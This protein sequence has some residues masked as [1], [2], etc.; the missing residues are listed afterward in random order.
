MLG[1]EQL[2]RRTVLRGLG[3]AAMVAPFGLTACSNGPASEPGTLLR[4]AQKKD[5]STLDPQ[6]QGGLESMNVLI[7]LFDTLTMRDVDNVLQPRLALS[8]SAVDE[9]TWRFVLRPG[10]KFHNGED[11][12]AEVVKFSI[13]RLIDPATKSTIVELRYVTSVNII[14][15]HTV[16]IISSTPDP[17]LPEKVSLFGGVMVPP[18]YITEVGSEGFAAKPIGTGPYTFVSWRKDYRIE[19]LANP[20][21]WN[22][23]PA[24]EALHFTPMPNAASALASLQSN[25]VDIVSGL[26]PEA[27][28]QLKG[29]AGVE[30]QSH[31]GIRMHFVVLNTLDPILGDVRVRRALNHAV[32]IPLIIEAV[33]DSRAKEAPTIVPR[34][35]FGFDPSVPPFERSLDKAKQLLAE[36]GHPDGITLSFTA[37]NADNL[38]CQALAGQLQKAGVTL[39]LNLL[40]P[41]TY[42]SRLASDDQSALGSMYLTG[43]TGWT[44]DGEA[45]MQ[46]YIRS[47]R[48]RSRIKDAE[49]DRL[50]DVLEQKVDPQVRLK[51]FGEMQHL[52]HDQ[53]FF[54]YL[55]QADL[56]YATN[57]LADW[58]PNVVGTLAMDTA[59]VKHG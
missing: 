26:T 47:D 23:K 15:E 37:S 22:G 45:T 36:A 9:H 20:E 2:S 34:E 7:N 58:R 32:D 28:L 39:E 18:A 4:V 44:L 50:I 46:S 59:T 52:L 53:A 14:D 55:Y 27:A 8:W 43:S 57:N 40:E 6:V 30:I 29:Y 13:E 33:L 49:A 3:A 11:F 17:V 10:V 19:M 35:A 31:P 54:L 48:K 42:S 16:D 21:H 41:G 56:L 5:P 25:G 38:I 51:A 1:S 24:F 12:N